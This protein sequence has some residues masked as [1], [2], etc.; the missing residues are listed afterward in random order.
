MDR[1]I[2]RNMRALHYALDKNLFLFYTKAIRQMNRTD[3]LLKIRM[4]K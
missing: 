2:S 1:S 3:R 4:S